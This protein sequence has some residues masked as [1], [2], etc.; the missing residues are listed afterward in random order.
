VARCPPFVNS[1]FL[2][3]TALGT[4]SLLRC[5]TSLQD[6]GPAERVTGAMPVK[7]P[8]RMTVKPGDHGGRVHLALIYGKFK[9]IADGKLA[10]GGLLVVLILGLLLA[11]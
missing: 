1:H 8:D 10:V 2:K 3:W 9:A 5:G 6:R 4:P 11:F 7:I